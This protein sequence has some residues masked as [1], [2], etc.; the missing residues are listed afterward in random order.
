[1]LS[2]FRKFIYG[3]QKH[4]AAGIFFFFFYLFPTFTAGGPLRRADDKTTHERK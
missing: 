4:Q 1:M 2:D 3:Q